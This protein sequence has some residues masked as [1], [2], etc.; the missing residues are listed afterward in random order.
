MGMILS[1][2]GALALVIG[3]I[4]LAV[5]GR[6]FSSEIDAWTPRLVDWLINRAVKRLPSDLQIRMDEEWRTFINDTPG[7]IVKLLRAFGL[8]R[9]ASEVSRERTL[10]GE[11]SFTER[12]VTQLFGAIV[13]FL[14]LPIFILT[15]VT[16]L[17]ERRWPLFIKVRSTNNPAKVHYRFLLGSGRGSKIIRAL[18]FDLLPISI[19]Y[20]MGDI[21]ISW[22]DWKIQ[23]G[24]IRGDW[25]T[26][27]ADTFSRYRSALRRLLKIRD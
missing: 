15:I 25:K 26:Y 7:K 14:L 12:A 1:A 27:K 18:S 22:H 11:L 21:V 24:K 20:L 4:L 9:G 5:V 19:S 2:S 8:S 17:F 10:S 6:L 13:L 16:L 3:G 23:F